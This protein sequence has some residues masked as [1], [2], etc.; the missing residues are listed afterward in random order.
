MTESCERLLTR[1]GGADRMVPHR[2]PERH[3]AQ[4]VSEAAASTEL[5]SQSLRLKLQESRRV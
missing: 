5:L 2:E 1:H 4:V 3:S